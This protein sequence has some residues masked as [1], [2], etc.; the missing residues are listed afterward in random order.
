MATE[1]P[2]WLILQVIASKLALIRT[3]GFF[4]DAGENVDLDRPENIEDAA[5]P[6]IALGEATLSFTGQTLTQAGMSTNWSMT[7]TCEGYVN[8]DGEHAER[9]AA[10]LKFDVIRAL[11]L[12]RTNDFDSLDGVRVTTY[13]LSGDAPTLRQPDGMNKITMQASVTVTFVVPP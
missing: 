8:D 2:S 13:T 6:R 3:P 10:R 12:V 5:F 4:T 11:G 9:D 7:A 1:A